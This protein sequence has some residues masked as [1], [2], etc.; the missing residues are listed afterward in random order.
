MAGLTLDVIT[1]I[2]AV[3]RLDPA[4]PV[5]LFGG[6]LTLRLIRN[7]GAAFS[8]GESFT[9]VFALLAVAGRLRS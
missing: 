3:R 7:P 2:I 8:L 9:F 5:R 1:K 4:E 6:L